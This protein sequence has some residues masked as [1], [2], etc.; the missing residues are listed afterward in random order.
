MSASANTSHTRVDDDNEPSYP[1]LPQRDVS[2]SFLPEPN[3]TAEPVAINEAL[4]PPIPQTPKVSLT[5]LLVSGCR[6]IQSFDPE[7][8]VARVKEL[9]W[10]GWPSRSEGM[11]VITNTQVMRG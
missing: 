3:N 5:F 9:M 6:K 11:F 10:N 8:T 7:T 2:P 4:E 1:P